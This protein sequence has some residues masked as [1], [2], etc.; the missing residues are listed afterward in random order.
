MQR[1]PSRRTLAV[2]LCLLGASIA[3]VWASPTPPKGA[4]YQYST[5]GALMRGLYDGTLTLGELKRHGDTGIGTVDKLDG[6]MVLLDGKAYQVR[7]DGRVLPVPDT[8]RT[9]FATVTTF[10]ADQS[11]DIE[12]PMDLDELERRLDEL[13]P[14]RNG[15]AAFRITGRFAY[16]KT[17]SVPGQKKPYPPLAD[18]AKQ[19]SVFEL[20]EVRG[21]LVGFR[22]PDYVT[23]LNVP[24]YHLHFLTEDRRSGGHVMAVQLTSG[25]AEAQQCATSTVETPR[26]PDFH[27]LDLRDDKRA[28]LLR[29]EKGR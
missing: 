4:C 10:R 25:R 20:R 2:L 23:A 19:Q 5:I 17:R 13:A 15:F 7:S 27:D 16:V 3:A 29:V 11:A 26:D 22:T 12:E 14:N 28:D 21:T 6:E 1:T 18:V 8:M 9:P 24:G